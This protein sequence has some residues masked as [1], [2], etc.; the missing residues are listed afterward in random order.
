M[1]HT[2]SHTAE[3]GFTMVVIAALFIAFA[4][5]AAAVVER[6]TI[7]QQIARRDA[8]VAQLH[9]LQNAIIEYSVFNRNS[10]NVNLYPCPADITL[11]TNSGEFG[12]AVHDGSNVQDCHTA[13]HP[14][15]EINIGGT[16][17][18]EGMVP[19][20]TLSQYGISTEDAFDPWNNKIVYVVN[21]KRT[22]NG[23][24][25]ASTDITINFPTTWTNYNIPKPDFI[26]ISLGKDGM[27]AY[28]RG[29]GATVSITCAA[30]TPPDTPIRAANCSQTGNYYIAPTY[31]A[32]DATT[33]SYFDDILVYFV[34]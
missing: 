11:E 15:G 4:I 18:D 26:L 16:A 13:P 25:T 23:D 17:I 10:G 12:V 33:A 29:Q 24:G 20:Q 28:K 27:G 5:V 22:P 32:A 6:N 21:H 8:A 19:V 9:K 2:L 1:K 3:R 34:Q 7:T 14:P 31:T 30:F